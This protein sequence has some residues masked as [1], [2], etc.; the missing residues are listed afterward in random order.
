MGTLRVGYRRKRERRRVDEKSVLL[1]P[2]YLVRG[3]GTVY[4]SSIILDT[5]RGFDDW[6]A[7]VSSKFCVRGLL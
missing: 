7:V 1:I 5:Y 6:Q 2:N 3:A 4:T